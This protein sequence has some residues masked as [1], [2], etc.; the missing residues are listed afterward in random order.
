[1]TLELHVHPLSSYC[2]KVLI[3][4]YELG[5][6]FEPV[7]VD[8]GDPAVRE[9]YL[10]LSPFGKIPAL[11][12]TDRG[13]EVYETSI[14]IEY[15]DARATGGPR[16]IPKDAGVALEARLWDRVFDLHV[17]NAFQP[18]VGDRLKPEEQ[19]DPAGVEMA[20]ARLRQAYDVLEQRLAGRTWAAG[21]AFTIADCAAAPALFYADV[22]EPIGAGRATLG[23]YLR[24]LMARPSVT[25][26]VAE[27]RPWF[28]MFPATDAE[29]AR[30]PG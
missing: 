9:R 15:L 13:A 22:I 5:T 1:M 17:H 27:A 4:A 29:R 20:R 26:A 12:D 19:R 10:R 2:W 30:M 16:L 28:P 25:R 21:E 24:R 14:M 7:T 6:P 18:I 23:A 8:L 11:R 3:A